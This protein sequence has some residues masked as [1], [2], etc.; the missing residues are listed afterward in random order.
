MSQQIDPET[1][2]LEDLRAAADAEVAEDTNE[3]GKPVVEAEDEDAPVVYRREID[4]GDGSG[5]QVFEAESM[6]AL[7]DKLS[8]AQAHATR[9]IRE[10]AAE[11][12]KRTATPADDAAQAQA[13]ADAEWL[14]SQEFTANP[15]AT[16]AK[17]FEKVVG[18][19]LT[20]FKTDLQRLSEFE[21]AQ[22]ETTAAQAFVA[23][24]ADDYVPT[25]ANGERLTR[26]LK[27]YKMDGT[28]ENIEQAFKD[29][30]ESGLLETKSE[31]TQGAE[32][33]NG[34]RIV[35]VVGHQ[36]KVASGISTRGTAKT[37]ASEPTE[38]D[39]AKMSLDQLREL[40]NKELAG[41]L[42]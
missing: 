38:E 39:I 25:P 15:S 18:K 35:T 14:L 40:A 9:K 10:Q 13:E 42:N 27:T 8:D 28:I 11:L 32:N 20:S 22:S 16:F 6:E 31:K 7:I 24:H 30:S 4:L 19:P 12:K 3:D 21:R 29:L 1:M 36:R 37:R 2:S 41:Q 26:Y 5:K 33:T 23:K 34:S 17:L